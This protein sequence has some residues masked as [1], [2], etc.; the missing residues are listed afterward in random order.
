MT[1]R[2]AKHNN[3]PNLPRIPRLIRTSAA[4]ALGGFAGL[5]VLWALEVPMSGG[6]L[7]FAAL[8][9]TLF[10]LCAALNLDRLFRRLWHAV[11]TFF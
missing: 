4:A 1:S 7:L 2:S 3:G 11:L 6:A 9:A 5:F 8:S 10:A